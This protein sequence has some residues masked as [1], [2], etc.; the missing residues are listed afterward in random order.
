VHLW[1]KKSS[2]PI[3]DGF[4]GKLQNLKAGNMTQNFDEQSTSRYCLPSYPRNLWHAV[5]PMITASR[6]KDNVC[7]CLEE[8]LGLL[9]HGTDIF[10]LSMVFLQKN[11]CLLK[12]TTSSF[13]SDRT[14][15]TWATF[16]SKRRL[17]R[18]LVAR[19]GNYMVYWQER[20]YDA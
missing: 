18:Q 5:P 14:V 20:N 2:Q 13:F 1:R 10:Q 17:Q 9:Y 15:R 3:P 12:V 4:I 6:S 8:L 16:R 19:S 7:H 11:I